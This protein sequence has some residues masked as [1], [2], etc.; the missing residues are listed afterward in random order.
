[1]AARNRKVSLAE[2]MGTK[3]ATHGLT[4]DK[5]PEVLGDAMPELPRTAVGRHR[6]IRSLQQRF[7][8][9]FRSLPGVS[10]L[11]A[12]FDRDLELERKVAQIAALKMRRK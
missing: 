5:L 12:E 3:G 8:P 11:V 1:M 6:L 7:G 10:D 9:N 4:L 2:V